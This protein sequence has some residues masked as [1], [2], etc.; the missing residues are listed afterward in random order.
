MTDGNT[1]NK[2]LF[3]VTVGTQNNHDFL[4]FADD[5]DEIRKEGIPFSSIKLG[6][7]PTLKFIIEDIKTVDKDDYYPPEDEKGDFEKRLSVVKHVLR[8]TA[9]ILITPSGGVREDDIALCVNGVFGRE[10]FGFGKDEII[11]FHKELTETLKE[12]GY[13]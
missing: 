2:Q 6:S 8:T 4:V 7:Y 11:A 1:E 10:G 5:K 9:H 12:H 3:R 13:I